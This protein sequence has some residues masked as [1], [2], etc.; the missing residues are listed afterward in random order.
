VAVHY[1]LLQ[2]LLAVAVAVF[3][4]IAVPSPSEPKRLPSGK[5]GDAQAWVRFW[6]PAQ[7]F[8]GVFAITFLH[9]LV[10]ALVV[11]CAVTAKWVPVTQHG[12]ALVNALC[13]VGVAEALLRANVAGATVS[14]AAKTLAAWRFMQDYASVPVVA[15]ARRHVQEYAARLMLDDPTLVDEAQHLVTYFYGLSPDGVGHQN[16]LDGNSQILL[17]NPH[18]R[19]TGPAADNARDK[20]REL[21]DRLARDGYYT[22]DARY[23]RWQSLSKSLPGQRPAPEGFWERVLQR[24]YDRV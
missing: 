13:Y 6:A 9:A 8:G 5:D 1:P 16:N 23:R 22:T 11:L 3:W 4:A 19:A 17:A 7:S 12:L 14:P 10:T 24:R 20:L 15:T 18:A 2:G 21:V